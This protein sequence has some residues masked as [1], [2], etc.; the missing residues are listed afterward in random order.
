MAEV[1]LAAL[2]AFSK[3][4]DGAVTHTIAEVETS[5]AQQVDR[6]EHDFQSISAAAEKITEEFEAKTADLINAITAAVQELDAKSAD[7]GAASTVFDQALTDLHTELASGQHV[8]A[9][10]ADT[11]DQNVKA[12]DSTGHDLFQQL[13][14]AIQSA[15]SALNDHQ[16]AAQT[17][18]QHTGDALDQFAQHGTDL[19]G[20]AHEAMQALE[21]TATHLLDQTV[22]MLNSQGEQTL[23]Q[24]TGQA[25]DVADNASNSGDGVLGV[26]NEVIGQTGNLGDQFGG[27]VDQVTQIVDNLVALVDALG[28]LVDLAEQL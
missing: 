4:L 21:Q 8:M 28:P 22:A 9:G 13:A 24:F 17:A 11:L 26:A 25:G 6:L 16:N 14:A 12:L 23:Q 7:L 3:E 15:E 27:A 10:A 19:A 20:H 18:F 2:H 5:S 1:D